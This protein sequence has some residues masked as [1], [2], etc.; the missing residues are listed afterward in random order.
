MRYGRYVSALAATTIALLAG[1]WLITAPWVLR[2][3]RPVSGW[4]SMVLTD[5]WTG[6]AVVVLTAVTFML[7]GRQIAHAFWTQS[8]PAAEVTEPVATPRA[9]TPT[10]DAPTDEA[11]DT[12]ANPAEPEKIPATV[13]LAAADIDELLVPIATALLTD[14]AQRRGIDGNHARSKEG[15]S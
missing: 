2:Y 4:G 3:P 7:Y 1:V 6:T 14:L 15:D 10:P 9:A 8:L 5:F 13:A 11:T 12:S